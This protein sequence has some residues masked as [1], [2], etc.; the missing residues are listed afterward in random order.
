MLHLPPEK[1]RHVLPSDISNLYSFNTV[2]HQRISQQRRTL[3]TSAVLLPHPSN[4]ASFLR[5]IIRPFK[6]VSSN[7]LRDSTKFIHYYILYHKSSRLGCHSVIPLPT[8]PKTNSVTAAQNNTE[9]HNTIFIQM[10]SYM[11]PK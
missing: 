6:V 4:S 10:C 3:D 8:G 9:Q 5:W 2:L 1:F 7:L 11:C